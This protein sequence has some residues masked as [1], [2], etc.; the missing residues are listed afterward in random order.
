MIRTDSLFS[1]LII[2]FILISLIAIIVLG[3]SMIYIINSVFYDMKEEEIIK[4]TRAVNNYI[5]NALADNNYQVVGNWIEILA[6]T[7]SG[8]VWLIDNKGYLTVS[9]PV[10]KKTP[11]KPKRFGRYKEV[12]GGEIFIQRVSSEYFEEP[13]LLVGLPIT[14][15]DQKSN[16]GLLVFTPVSGIDETVKQII[17]L[18]LYSSLVTILLATLVAYTWSKSLSSPLKQISNFAINLG[19]GDF[20]KTINLESSKR[21]KEID[22]LG[23]S[24]NYLSST[25]KQSVDSLVEEKNKLQYVLAG[26]E[27]G[28]LA[29]NKTSRIILINRSAQSLLSV[30]G[31]EV[32]GKTLKKGIVEDEVLRIYKKVMETREIHTEDIF[33]EEKGVKKRIMVHLTPIY[34]QEDLFWGVVGLFQDISERWRFEQLQKEFIANVSHDLKAPLSS[35]KGAT[36]LLLDNIIDSSEKREKYLKMIFEESNRLENMVKEILELDEFKGEGLK[37]IMEEVEV[38]QLLTNL[39]MVFDKIIKNE[40]VI[41]ETVIPKEEIYVRADKNKLKQVILNLLDN[42]YKFSGEEGKIQLGAKSEKGRVKFWVSDQGKGIPQHELNNIWERFYKVDKS[43]TPGEKGSG[44]GLAIVKRI[45]EEHG[46]QVFVSS[47]INQ[48]TT[49]GFYL[50]LIS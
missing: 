41:L 16:F 27:E 35:I 43:R 40:K 50:K 6:Q 45:V 49:I 39:Q 18:M 15:A 19:E 48:G 2:R 46:G 21:I 24:I 7:H 30:R 1:K 10:E 29:V 36:E 26:M 31:E 32:S 33:L 22:N 44:L 13:M 38:G 9:Y 42:A 28:V 12:L 23:E 34:I 20:G 14:L 5:F 3:G 47:K 25:L 4:G 8:K 17:R 11:A 37:M